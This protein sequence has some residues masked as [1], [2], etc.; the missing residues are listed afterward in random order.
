MAP[1]KLTALQNNV[2]LLR[3]RR[4]RGVDLVREL[5]QANSLLE[6]EVAP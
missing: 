4:L 5:G 3:A 1:K 2:Y 6:Y